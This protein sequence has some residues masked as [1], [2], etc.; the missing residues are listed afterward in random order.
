MP[1]NENVIAALKAAAT[2]AR[3]P[4]E[5]A[6]RLVSWLDELEKGNFSRG[7]DDEERLIA[8]LLEQVV[9]PEG[10]AALDALGEGGDQ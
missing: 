4:K 1:V 2:S 3:Q 5:V 10:Q 9:L 6:H 7:T 8:D